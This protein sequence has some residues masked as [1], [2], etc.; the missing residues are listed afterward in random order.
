M[1]EPN[2]SYSVA[3]AAKEMLREL[4]LHFYN[5]NLLHILGA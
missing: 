1:F 4:L 2:P 5:G 3:M